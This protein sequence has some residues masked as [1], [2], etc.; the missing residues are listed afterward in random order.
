MGTT[1]EATFRAEM[2]DLVID[3]AIELARNGNSRLGDKEV[4]QVVSL[5]IRKPVGPTGERGKAA[6][7]AYKWALSKKQREAE[8]CSVLDEY[9]WPTPDFP[10]SVWLSQ[11][12]K[13]GA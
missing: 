3:A 8:A 13:D 2:L 1:S 9:D 12:D 6:I 4:C 7:A 10:T 5:N 11:T